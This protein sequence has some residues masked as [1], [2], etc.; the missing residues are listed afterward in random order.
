MTAEVRPEA[1]AL[2]ARNL[3][4]V[5]RSGRT[6]FCVIGH[7]LP[8]QGLLGVFAI[9]GSTEIV[10]VAGSLGFKRDRRNYKRAVRRRVLTFK[11]A[12]PVPVRSLCHPRSSEPG[13]SHRVRT[14]TF[15]GSVHILTL[16]PL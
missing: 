14:P 9:I 4:I 12:V 2:L 5:S 7:Y 8:Q 11:L 13:V 1:D 15:E 3:Q 6:E 16:S 10:T